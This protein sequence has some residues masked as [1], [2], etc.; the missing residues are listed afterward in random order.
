MIGTLSL[1][2]TL[3]S[4]RAGARGRAGG[5]IAGAACLLTLAFGARA[6]SLAP[7]PMLAALLLQLGV[8]ML[9][10]LLV[11]GWRTMQYIEYVQM[12]LIFGVIVAWDF[13]AGVA[14]GLVIACIAFA[15]N[16]GRLRLLKLGLSRAVYTG[17]VDR[18]S[19]LMEQLAING[20]RIQIA[21]LHGFVF[22]GSANR[23]L[24]QIKEIV[25]AQSG[26]CRSLILDFRQV[27][28]IDS[29][30]VVTLVKL[31]QLAENRDFT[32]VFSGLPPQVERVLRV[33]KLIDDRNSSA[34]SVFGD[35][36]SALEWCE[37][38]LLGTVLTREE[39]LDS[40]DQWLARE[41]GRDYFT[42]LVP[43][44]TLIECGPGDLRSG[45]AKRVTACTCSSR[46]RNRDARP[47]GRTCA[48]AA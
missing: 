23:L 17:S 6:L 47:A 18:S 38:R 19:D 7:V 45:R 32:V 14:V 3:F 21:W 44:V 39:A 9:V 37:D 35:C 36:D 41:I 1:S 24:L 48:C 29:S 13:V 26:S 2:R 11:K 42:R 16:I 12:L 15:F 46:P 25:A 5:F 34:C 28:G 4:F 27:L 22:F 20:D 40:A 33:G 10:D 31:L 30:A 43:Y 8:E